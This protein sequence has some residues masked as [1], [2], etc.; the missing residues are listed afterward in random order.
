[1]KK[2]LPFLVLLFLSSRMN[3]QVTQKATDRFPV[4]PSCENLQFQ[5]LEICFNNQVQDFVYNNFKVPEDLNQS[6][7]KGTVIVLFEVNESGNFKVLYVDAI[8]EKLVDECKRV[9]GKMPKIYPATHN[10][11]PT[12]AKFTIK[13][14]KNYSLMKKMC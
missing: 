2:I 13:I 7:Y 6:N 9:F 14:A 4:F 1:M 5:A 8:Y 10:G 12:Y 11:N 3:A